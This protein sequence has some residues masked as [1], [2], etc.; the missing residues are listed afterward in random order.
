MLKQRHDKNKKER[1]AEHAPGESQHQKPVLIRFI[2]LAGRAYMA[3][4][5]QE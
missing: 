2:T 5:S 4:Y 3:V 1:A